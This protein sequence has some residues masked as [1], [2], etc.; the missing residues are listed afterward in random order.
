MDKAFAEGVENCRR[1]PRLVDYLSTLPPKGGRDRE[2]YWNRPV[3]GF[4]DPQARDRK[5]VV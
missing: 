2:D 1:C 4:G 5:S 3:P